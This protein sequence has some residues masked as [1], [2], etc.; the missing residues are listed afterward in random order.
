MTKGFE[1]QLN[2]S[3]KKHFGEDPFHVIAPTERI[4]DV[5]L[6]GISINGLVHGNKKQLAN[7]TEENIE[8]ETSGRYGWGS[9]HVRDHLAPGNFF[10]AKMFGAETD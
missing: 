2:E 6:G 8:A 4:Y 9:N 3:L 7:N 10:F 5:V 1:E